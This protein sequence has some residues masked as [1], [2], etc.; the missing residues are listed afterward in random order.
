MNY[1]ITEDVEKGFDAAASKIKELE[2]QVADLPT[3][4]ATLDQFAESLKKYGKSVRGGGDDGSYKGFWGSPEEAKGF[5]ELVLA[6]M[7]RKALAE[8]SNATGGYLVPTEMADRIIQKLGK[9]G[10]FRKNALV[11]PVGSDQLNVP[12]VDSDLTVY[13]PGEGAALTASDVG[14]GAVGLNMKKFCCLCAVSSELEEDSVIAIGE[15]LGTSITRSMAKKEDLIGFL[16]DGTSTYFGMVGI[17]GALRA[18]DAVIA[19]I[20]GLVV[21]TGNAYSEITL[22]DFEDVVA[23]LH[24]DAEEDAKWYVSRK[25][26]YGV[27]YPLARAAGVADLFSIL[28]DKKAKYFMGYEV[29]FVSAMPSVEANSQ[30]CALLG[31]LRLGAYLGQRRELTVDQSRDVYFA[32][33][34]IGVRGIERIGI[35]VFGVGDT[36]EA[37]AIVGL[38]TAAA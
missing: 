29:E 28:T 10:K 8:S 38:I 27:M 9:Y 7:G 23:L 26:F 3:L 5:G 36:T 4:K 13:C 18:V 15:I 37:G 30:I 12:K 2:K 6:A 24:E 11:V 17:T 31:D 14:F 16:G 34:Q 33:D 32:S 21:A 35:S 19:N 22:G 20:K 25:F 1:A